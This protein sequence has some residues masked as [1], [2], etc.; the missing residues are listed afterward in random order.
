[1]NK[2]NKRKRCPR[3]DV[4][5]YIENTKFKCF[6]CGWETIIEKDNKGKDIQIN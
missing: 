5:T 3:C 2:R 1:M 4:T 6:K